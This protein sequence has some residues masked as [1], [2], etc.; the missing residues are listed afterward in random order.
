MQGAISGYIKRQNDPRFR[1]L[2]I[3]RNR[4]YWNGVF[5]AFL[6]ATLYSTQSEIG[7]LSEAGIFNEGGYTYPINCVKKSAASGGC[8]NPSAESTNNTGWINFII[9]PV[10]GSLWLIGEDTLERYIADPLVGAHPNGFWYKVIRASLNPPRSLANMLRGR[11]PWYRDYENP[12]EYES[13]VVRRFAEALEAE[14]HEAI[15]LNLFYSSL[16]LRTN[17]A[18]CVGC[19]MT[20]DGAG[21]ESGFRVRKYL[22]VISVVRVQPSASTL[23]SLKVGSPLLTAD[24]GIR[25]G[26]SGQHFALKA[27]LSPGF[28]SYSDTIPRSPLPIRSPRTAASSTST[29]LPRSPAISTSPRISPFAPPLSRC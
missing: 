12:T 29:L 21:A 11:Y 16:S 9:T 20:T 26:Y 7:P 2:R 18:G 4:A 17:Y 5:R 14:P 1:D 25:S 10:V 28:A 8:L 23:S 15:D 27:S 3:S 19:R 24:F 13:P 22:D 6:W